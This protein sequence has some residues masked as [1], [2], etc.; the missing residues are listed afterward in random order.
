[1]LK[2]IFV[3]LILVSVILASFGVVSAQQI[4]KYE[5]LDFAEPYAREGEAMTT[6]GCYYYE[7]QPFYIVDFT[8][9]EDLF[10]EIV[11]DANTGEVIKDEGIARKIIHA[12]WVIDSI[13][14]VLITEEVS[15]AANLRDAVTIFE[16]YSALFKEYTNS[17]YIEEKIREYAANAATSHQLIADDYS[18]C[19]SIQNEIIDIES[20]IIGKNLNVELTELYLSKGDQF[21]QEYDTLDKHINKAREDTIAFYDELI[22][23][24]NNQTEKRVLE[25]EKQYSLNYLLTEQQSIRAYKSYWESYKSDL[26]DSTEWFIEE[27]KD[28][29]ELTEAPGFEAIFA[30]AGL[31]VV[32]Y[33]LR[34]G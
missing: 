12:S 28:R 7:D 34:R 30:I 11:I 22:A 14:S 29:F 13:D 20:Q 33:L 16:S 6:Y 4:S 23:S 32:A 9:G 8:I 21:V 25:E 24:T 17:P 27:M 18:R 15:S 26:D 5:V 1:M 31:L 3:I 10:G 2:K 19:L